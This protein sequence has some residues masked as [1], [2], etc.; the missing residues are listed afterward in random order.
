MFARSLTRTALFAAA[1][2]VAPTLGFAQTTRGSTVPD[3]PGASEYAP[4]QR[5]KA[6]GRSAKTFAPGQQAK[7]TGKAAETFAPGQQDGTT[8]TG[9]TPGSTTR[10]R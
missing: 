2:I 3:Q 10:S 1:L 8:T 7:R 9:S 6:T 5:A 4:G